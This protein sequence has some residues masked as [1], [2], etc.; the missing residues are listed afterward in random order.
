MFV[1]I[2]MYEFGYVLVDYFFGLIV[3]DVFVCC[4]DEYD[5]GVCVYYVD[6]IE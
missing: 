6:C 1:V 4:I 5:L 3:E 2:W